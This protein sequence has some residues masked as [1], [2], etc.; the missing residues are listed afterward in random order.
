LLNTVQ[1]GRDLWRSEG[2]RARL[3]W[4]LVLSG[5]VVYGFELRL[6][7]ELFRNPAGMGSEG[8]L[9]QSTSLVAQ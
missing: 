2:R 1:M 8:Y 3:G 6:G 4:A 5:L 9:Y 7:W